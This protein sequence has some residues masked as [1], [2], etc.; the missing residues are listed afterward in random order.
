MSSCR[1]QGGKDA[2]MSEAKP[3]LF[4]EVL[5]GFVDF[6]PYAG[7]EHFSV[8]NVL[9]MRSLVCSSEDN[10]KSVDV[11]L[12]N[13]PFGTIQIQNRKFEDINIYKNYH[14]EK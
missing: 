7:S 13:K 12:I 4:F 8:L 10:D 9:C 3:A 5:W 2:V 6:L 1:I 14:T 11:F